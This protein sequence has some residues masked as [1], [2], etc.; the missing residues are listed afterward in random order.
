MFKG[1]YMP[2]VLNIVTFGDFHGLRWRIYWLKK[3]FLIKQNLVLYL[4]AAC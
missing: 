4:Y 2:I 1:L 3:S